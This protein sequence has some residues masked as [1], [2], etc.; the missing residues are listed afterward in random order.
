MSHN[1]G[2]SQM[3]LETKKNLIESF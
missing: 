1:E 3:S 2:L